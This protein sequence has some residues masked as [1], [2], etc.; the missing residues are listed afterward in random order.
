MDFVT[1]FKAAG[2]VEQLST[3]IYSA[4]KSAKGHKRKLL[5]ELQDNFDVIDLWQ[6]KGF[7]IDKV[8]LKLERKNYESAIT[9]NF[10]FNAL[11][12]SALSKPTTRDVPQFQ[13]YVGWSTAMLFDNLY[14]KIKQLRDIVEMDSD[15]VKIDKAARLGNVYKIMILLVHHISK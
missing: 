5:L 1:A 11:E 2:L 6:M 7:P 4:L 9:D 12:R 8:I 3:Q 10:N 14:R 15:N 13:K